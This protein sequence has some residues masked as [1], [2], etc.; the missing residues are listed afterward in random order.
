ME[1]A[2]HYKS[3]GKCKLKPQQDTTLCSLEWLRLKRVIASN[4]GDNAE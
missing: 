2:Q 3:L 4:V 1:G